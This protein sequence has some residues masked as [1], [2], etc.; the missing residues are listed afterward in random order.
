MQSETEGTGRR[1]RSSSS[2]RILS[3]ARALAA[4]EAEVDGDD[5]AAA[6]DGDAAAAEDGGDT[7][8][9]VCTDFDLAA[10]FVP[11]A[12]GAGNVS[13]GTD[14]ADATVAE[15]PAAKRRL[16]GMDDPRMPLV[17]T[18]AA[19][20]TRVVMR[21]ALLEAAAE[22]TDDAAAEG[23]AVTAA[24]AADVDFADA[25]TLEPAAAVLSDPVSGGA[26][27]GVFTTP[28]G[29]H[30][31]VN[32]DVVFGQA[33]EIDGVQYFRVVDMFTPSR[34]KPQPDHVF[35]GTDDIT[36]AWGVPPIRACCAAATWCQ[37]CFAH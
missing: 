33:R 2:R 29:Q 8:A 35:E 20:V 14:E 37:L 34:S 24:P 10:L 23:E 17:V 30:A 28:A 32:Q 22:P 5:A 16:M 21:R 25:A 11:G 7:A 26:C 27:D 13:S 31:M 6:E 4:A 1:L 19:A 15:E 36:D 12:L 18:E 3:N 9:G